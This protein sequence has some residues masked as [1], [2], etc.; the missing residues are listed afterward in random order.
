MHNFYFSK[1]L[2]LASAVFLV[3]AL[4]SCGK[5]STSPGRTPATVAAATTPPANATVGVPIRPGPS[6]LVTDAGGSPVSGAKVSFDVTAGNGAVQYPIVTT[7]ENGVASAGAWQ[8]GGAGTNTVTA[9]V[10]GL[11]PV[12][13]NT[14]AVVGSSAQI[15]KRSGDKQIGHINTDLPTPLTVQVVNPGGIGV[16][17]QTV[18]FTVT[19]GGGSIA[20]SPAV[21]DA[22]GFA[23]SGTWT[24]GPTFGTHSVVAQTGSLQTTFT[25][26]VDPCEDRLSS[27]AVGGTVNGTLAFSSS[28]CAMAGAATDR[29]SVATGT[30]AVQIAMSSADFDALINV[31]N[32]AGTALYAT[33]DNASSGTTDAG[34]RLITAAT[35]KTVDATS[36]AAG[37]TGNYTLSVT[38]TSSD[39][40]NCSPVYIEVGASTDQTLAT[41]DCKTNFAPAA[42]A[43][44]TGEGVW[45]NTNVSGDAFLVYIAAGTTVRISQTAQPLDAAIA[46]Y[47]PDG[48]LIIFRDNGGVGANPEVINYT[49]TVSGYYRIVA[50]SYCLLYNDPYQA[51]CDYG[52]YTLSVITP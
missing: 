11:A 17:G 13:F 33:N 27:L 21:T 46:F 34:L 5:D 25:A 15:L 51:G 14:T 12:T 40:A 18:T 6:V 50:G 47:G 8:I 9:T 35:T 39:V 23:T 16:S 52:P 22:N 42:T 31:W 49:A 44:Q 1:R 24:L 28:R 2:G 10:D 32:A 4:T 43:A 36:A 19:G 37:K 41:T 30:G 29:Y 45:K 48:S 26:L 38:S 7:D 20:G 3:A